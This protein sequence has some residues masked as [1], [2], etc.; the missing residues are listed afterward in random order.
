[1]SDTPPPPPP[2][3]PASPPPPPAAPPPAAGTPA[4]GAY[5]PWIN[6]VGGYIL[7]ALAIV[8]IYL[9]A[10]VLAAI[11]GD[12]GIIF[13][14]AGYVFAIVAS[15]RFIIQRAHLGYDLGDRVVGQRLVREA[16]NQPMGSGWSV[17]GR[18]IAHILDAL[19][20]Y[21]GFLWPLWDA[22]K[23]TFADKVLST[24]VVTDETPARHEA[25]DL[26]L[27]AVMFWTPVTKS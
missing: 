14:L 13:L 19:P 10:V 18:Q 11:L 6:R 15:I 12:I 9:V 21:L 3:P 17:F 7:R 8:P 1:M 16:T 22:K 2:P 4:V 25:K 23:Q 24:V 20:C 27:N 26:F 5:S